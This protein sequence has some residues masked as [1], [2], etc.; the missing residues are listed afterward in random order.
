MDACGIGILLKVNEERFDQMF[1][2]EGSAY[3]Y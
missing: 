2:R 3:E 1:Y